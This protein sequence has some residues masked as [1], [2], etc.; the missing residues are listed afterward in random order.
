[1]CIFLWL[2][3][4]YGCSVSTYSK[5]CAIELIVT[6]QRHAYDYYDNNNNNT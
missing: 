6:Q 1:M 2:T 5:N 3:V 4:E